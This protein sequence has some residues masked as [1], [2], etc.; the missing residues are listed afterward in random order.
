MNII[1]IIHLA[2]ALISITGFTIRGIW[3]LRDSP[4][5]QQK[6][7]KVLPHINDT[8]LLLSAVVL[9]VQMQQAPFINGWLTAKVLGL[10]VYI[11]LGMVALRF[12]KT[13]RVKTLAYLSAIAV[14]IYIVLVA[15]TKNPLLSL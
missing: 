11:G 4:R 3:M 6:W 9:A 14:F 8:V 10:L 12:G 13:K 15:I 2:T 1:K 5:L 7:V